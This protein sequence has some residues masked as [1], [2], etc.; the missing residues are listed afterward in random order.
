MK[1]DYSKIDSYE[2]IKSGKMSVPNIG[3]GQLIPMII[4]NEN[5]AQ[6]LKQLIKIHCDLPPGDVETIWGTPISLFTPKILR[7]RFNF[8]KHLDLSFCL[9]FEVKKRFNLIDEI[10]QTKA[11]YLNVGN[12]KTES[13]KLIQGGILVEVPT[14]NAKLKWEKLLL[15]TVKDIYKKE[16]LNKK[17][18]TKSLW[19]GSP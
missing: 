16:K 3:G 5:K 14:T 6:K 15:K 19:T 17:E 12:I 13:A 7:L 9:N 18:L 11:I 4:I 1:I 2:I 10:F 8:S